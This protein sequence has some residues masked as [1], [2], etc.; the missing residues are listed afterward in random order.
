MTLASMLGT[1]TRLLEL[2]TVHPQ[3]DTA[4]NAAALAWLDSEERWVNGPDGSVR[5]CPGRLSALRVSHSKPVFV[6][7][8]CTGATGA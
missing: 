5:A 6:W 4:A 7:R 2:P 8:V 3:W 1:T